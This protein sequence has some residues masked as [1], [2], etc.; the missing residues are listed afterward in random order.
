MS[1]YSLPLPQEDSDPTCRY[2]CNGSAAQNWT[3]INGTGPSKVQLAGTNFC[4]DAGSNPGNGVG[5][6]IWTCFS[7]LPQQ[8]WYITGDNRIALENQGL[9][10]D[11]TNGNL[12]NGNQVQT[13][14]CTNNNNN[15]VWTRDN[16]SPPPPP[17]QQVFQL[18]PNG[19]NAKC[20]DVRAAAFADGTPVQM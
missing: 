9:C 1:S 13:W 6:K 7:G 12:Q 19:N 8:Q 5:M 11:L 10:L 17:V 15:Q 3:V 2:D 16:Q 4:L 20:V 18:H 14:Q